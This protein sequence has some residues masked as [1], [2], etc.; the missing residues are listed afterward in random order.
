MLTITAVYL[1]VL[2]YS[3]PLQFSPTVLT[4]S[5][6]RSRKAPLYLQ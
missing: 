2:T 5:S 6:H 3:Y 4:Y 1:A